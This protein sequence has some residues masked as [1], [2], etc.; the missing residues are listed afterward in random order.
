MKKPYL[1]LW[2]RQCIVNDTMHG[3]FLNL[4]LHLRK[5]IRDIEKQLFKI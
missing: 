1:D 2:Q 5:F 4:N 3:A